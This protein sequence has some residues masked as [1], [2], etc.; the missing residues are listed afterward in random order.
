MKGKYLLSCFISVVFALIT[1][2]K[3]DKQ[4]RGRALYSIYCT[5]CHESVDIND[6][7]TKTWD[8]SVLPEMAAKMG[9][10]EKGYNPY[11]GMGFR[12]MEATIQSGQY[13][14]D[15]MISPEDWKVL[16]EYILAMAPDSLPNSIPT[17]TEGCQQFRPRMVDFD[18]SGGAYVV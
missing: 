16:R 8:E 3:K 18:S 5:S 7:P 9:I 15:P 2:C 13:P 4:E 6:L 12:K 11:E 14:T 1:S 17:I 10:R